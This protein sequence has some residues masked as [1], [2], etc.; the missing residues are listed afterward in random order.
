MN[1]ANF[2]LDWLRA[3]CAGLLL[4]GGTAWAQTETNDTSAPPDSATNEAPAVVEPP[5]DETPAPAGASKSGRP[6]PAYRGA[7]MQDAFKGA[8]RSRFGFS[9]RVNKLPAKKSAKREKGEWRRN[10]ELG[11]ATARGNSDTLR[12]DGE[13]SASKETEQNYFYIKAGGRYGE[14]DK[15]KDTENATGEARFQHRLTERMYA[16]VDGYGLHDSIADLD[17]RARASLALGRQF[18][19]SDRTALS[20]EAGPGYVAEKKAGES[21]GFLAGRVAQM[22]EFLVTDS[23]QIWQSVEYVP[24][25]EDSRVYYV[26]A[27]VGLETVLLSSL[28]LKFTVEDRYDSNPAEGKEGNDLLTTTSLSW[29]F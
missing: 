13:A 14:S 24:N 15:E 26:N 11:L 6:P 9:G 4:W 22:L 27:E 3:A 21:E 1:M 20:A 18:V 12:Y 8:A 29:S 19:L 7:D 16:G 10:L 23:L 5:V 28:S 17:Y 25:L 2:K